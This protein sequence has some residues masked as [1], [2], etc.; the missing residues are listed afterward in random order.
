MATRYD[1]LLVAVDGSKTSERAADHAIDLA[2]RFDSTLTVMHVVDGDLLALD[3]RGQL[4]A[5]QLEA[6]ATEIVEKTVERA[7][8]MGVS[9]EPL[10]TRGSPAAEIL[11]AIDARE[12]DLVV[13][14]SHGRTGIDKFLLG[15]VSE[16]VVRRSTV[17][18]LTV[19][20]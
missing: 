4:L 14:G 9:A 13:V 11:S 5:D 2:K 1:H 16:R 15:S 18:V 12:P 17:P 10:I 7:I 8:E 20:G 3:A 6:D 19:R